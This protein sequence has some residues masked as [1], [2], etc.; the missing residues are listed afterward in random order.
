MTKA[1]KRLSIA[2]AAA[3]LSVASITGAL[4][5][6]PED[7]HHPGP[8][9]AAPAQSAAD[10]QWHMMRGGGPMLGMMA[11]NCPMM[12]GMMEGADIPSFGEGRIAF[13][14]AELAIT[15][16]Q[17]DLWDAYAGAL[18]TNFQSMHDMRRTMKTRMSDM[19]PVERLEAHLAA[20]DG[21]VKAL[22]EVEPSLTALYAALSADQKKTADQLLT[23]MGCMM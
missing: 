3:A 22:K 9:T 20:M 23:H 11:A 16:A 7:P 14:K 8:L 6:E 15:H 4:A 2:T 1:M 10:T 19:T 21:R 12:G 17:K 18:R 13:L 5:Q